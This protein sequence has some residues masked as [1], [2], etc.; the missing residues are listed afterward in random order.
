MSAPV[1]DERSRV[2]AASSAAASSAAAWSA[3]AWSDAD[4][5]VLAGDLT[6]VLAYVT[7]AG[8]TVLTPVSPVGL[9]DRS[10]GTVTFTTSL[11]FGRK[12]ERI[13]ANPKVALAY[14]ARE[15]GF[16]SGARFVLVQGLARFD[17][18]PDRSLLEA[19]VRP[20]SVPFL[21]EPKTGPFW[22]RWLSAYYAD[23]V[24]VTV[25]VERVISWDNLA[26]DGEASVTGAAVPGTDPPPQRPPRGGVAPRVDAARAGRRLRRLPHTLIGYVGAD[27][28]PVVAPVDLPGPA[29]AGINVRGARLAGGA[30]AGLPGGR[31]AGLLGHRYGPQ[32]VGIEVRQYTGWLE[33]GVFAPHTERGFRAPPNKTLMM[34]ANGWM[35]RRGGAAGAARDG[36]GGA[37]GAGAVGAGA[38]G[39]GAVGA[40][41][42]A[43]GAGAPGA[44][45]PHRSFDPVLVGRLEGRAWATY[46]RREWLPLL[47][48]AIGL[49]RHTF[50]LPWPATLRGA[51]L[52]LRANQ[53]WAPVPDNDPDGARATMERFYRMLAQR[54]GE[55]RDPATAARLEVDWW[56]VHRHHQR[57]APDSSEEPLIEALVALY[58][59][60]YSA[61]PASVRTAAEERALAMRHSDRWVDEGCKLDSPLLGEIRA[62]LVRS[63]ASLL[64]AVHR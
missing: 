59:Y 23:R 60:V 40:G 16:A 4:D 7:P 35:A 34:L 42:G 56:R 41:A 5:E 47:R 37:G 45:K 30:P 6:A 62:A 38:V 2:D 24:L 1:I 19:V 12:L 39:A 55:P 46:Y 43:V 9:R 64:A 20:A 21:G 29:S 61:D 54:Y 57:D 13:R 31:R 17:E 33:G 27:G 32:L 44:V 63:Y 58:A 48:A 11:G 25:E 8:G 22:D 26:C 28:F 49:T 52:V 51:W 18:H 3:A 14:H 10:A 53:L 50:G 36:G 15:H